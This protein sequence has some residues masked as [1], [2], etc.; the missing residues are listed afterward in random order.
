[1][2][3]GVSKQQPFSL[4]EA[5]PEELLPHVGKFLPREIIMN[6]IQASKRYRRTLKETSDRK[7]YRIVLVRPSPQAERDLPWED[8]P[9]ELFSGAVFDFNTLLDNEELLVLVKTHCTQLFAITNF[10]IC[11]VTDVAQAE[12]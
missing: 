12:S 1:M 6:L 9:K 3:A 5:N 10:D 2:L 8:C 11:E 7:R 4:L